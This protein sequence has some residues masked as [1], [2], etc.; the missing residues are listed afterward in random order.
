MRLAKPVY[1]FLPLAY[2]VIGALAILL[3]YVDPAGPYG[4]IAFGIGL[5]AEIAALTVFLHRQDCRAYKREYPGRTVG[6]PPT[7]NS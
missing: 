1:E 2:V 6:L 7:F 3:V 4:L 5:L